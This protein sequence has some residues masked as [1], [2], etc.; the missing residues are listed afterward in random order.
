MAP[1]SHYVLEA[2]LYSQGEEYRHVGY[3]N[4]VFRTQK[5]AAAYYDRFNP[6]SRMRP[7]NAHGT[8]RSD[9]DTSTSLRFVVRAYHLEKMVVPAFGDPAYS[10]GAFT[11][12]DG[13]IDALMRRERAQRADDAVFNATLNGPTIVLDADAPSGTPERAQKRR[14]TGA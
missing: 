4:K 1:P 7:L 10:G 9:W 13:A 14:R 8:W 6:R 11:H 5:Q 12:P 3:V 2:Q